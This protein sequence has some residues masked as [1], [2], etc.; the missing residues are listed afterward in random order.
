MHGHRLGRLATLVLFCSLLCCVPA[1]AIASFGASDASF[2][3]DG[4]LTL[5]GGQTS[6]AQ[7]TAVALQS[8]RKIIAAGVAMV[9]GHQRFALARSLPDSGLDP[10]FG[11]GTGKVTTQVG[12][13]DNAQG[14]A[15]IVQPDGKIVMVGTAKQDNETR[16]ALVRYEAGGGL[17]GGFGSGG[18]KVLPA[19]ADGV[20]TVGRAVLAS[21]G[22]IVLTG[23]VRDGATVKVFVAR[24]GGDGTSDAGFGT[25][26]VQRYL[27]GD[28]SCATATAL[29]ARPDG[30]FVAF[31]TACAPKAR[32]FILKLGAN[33]ARVSS[34]GTNGDVI[35]DVAAATPVTGIVDHNGKFVLVGGTIDPNTSASTFHTSIARFAADGS[36][37][38]SF[39]TGGDGWTEI[40][41]QDVYNAID[42]DEL[43]D[44]RLWITAVAEVG[45][46]PIQGAWGSALTSANGI[47]DTSYG[48]QGS[49][50]LADQLGYPQTTSG[51]RAGESIVDGTTLVTA[52]RASNTLYGGFLEENKTFG[53]RRYTA[54][55][56]RDTHW[57]SYSVASTP[58]GLTTAT[59]LRRIVPQPDGS[60]LVAGDVVEDSV[61]N[62]NRH[63][64]TIWRITAA[65]VPDSAWSGDGAATD[66]IGQLASFTTDVQTASSGNVYA[67]GEANDSHS[68]DVMEISEYTSSGN[69]ATFGTGGTVLVDSSS[70]GVGAAPVC[71]AGPPSLCFDNDGAPGF[72]GAGRFVF[73]LSDGVLAVGTAGSVDSVRGGSGAARILLVRLNADGTPKAGFGLNGQVQFF[74]S[75][76]DRQVPLA[77]T[78]VSGGTK[79]R[80]ATVLGDS[81]GHGDVQILQFNLSDG[82]LDTTF[83]GDGLADATSTPSTLFIH[84]AMA[85]TDGDD[86]AFAGYA[87][88]PFAPTVGRLTGLGVP[89]AG[90]GTN[91]WQTTTIAGVNG[92]TAGG[93]AQ[94]GSSTIVG[95]TAT[96]SAPRPPAAAAYLQ[97]GALDTSFGSGGLLATARS[98]GN[99][100][101]RDTQIDAQ[102]RLLLGAVGTDPALGGVATISR[103][104]TG[105]PSA[106][107]P[108][109]PTTG[110]ASATGGTTVTPT[111]TCTPANFDGA[112]PLTYD[113]E[114]LRD[115]TLIAGAAANT[116]VPASGDAG[117]LIACRVTGHNAYGSGKAVSNAVR[118][119]GTVVVEPDP[120]TPDEPGG[121]TDPGGGPPPPS[122]PASPGS[123]ATPAPITVSPPV[124]K[125]P[126]PT[127]ASAI[128][129]SSVF[130]LPSSKKCISRRSFKIRIR[131][132]K[133]IKLISASVTVNNKRAKTLKGKRITAGVSLRGLPKGKVT[134][135]VSAKTADGRTVK[136]TRK[137]RTCAG[138]SKK[139]K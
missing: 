23:T 99:F 42:V 130:T 71:S 101:S 128:K 83:D 22:D 70:A 67:T 133:G 41:D 105:A 94:L 93:I 20:L 137:Y 25:G 11:G 121:P 135:S 80:V 46:N 57:N 37:D 64:S 103:F 29:S 72:G 59:T 116:Y 53:V 131:Q 109:P 16:A 104:I 48:F 6:S 86:F 79:L 27:V 32:G 92:F 85:F 119:P 55:G 44:G 60:L 34:F 17:D 82:T 69:F 114:W 106:D 47:P 31:G 110:A 7:A 96:S 18:I 124:S 122:G 14:S 65:G 91:G 97:T 98:C 123:A 129:P 100:S 30:T 84:S 19:L 3:G 134:V 138:S 132:P 21:D 111:V 36:L 95:V 112:Q 115:T 107:V 24:I 28:G 75:G 87:S 73:P 74:R 66:A 50:A 61:S 108:C 139:R 81:S 1:S 4:W 89:F 13:S 12:N 35:E 9:D 8:D 125:K 52:G 102:S 51:E 49:G 33:G 45:S 136:E 77:A 15:V 113:F 2:S 68:D 120:T 38:T 88:A 39:G 63:I 10:A 76:A 117:H 58:F 127:S 62:G 126:V 40:V 90:F 5:R 26:G 78:L 118:L 54:A 56:T 43:A